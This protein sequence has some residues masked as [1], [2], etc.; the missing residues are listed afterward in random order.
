M[1]VYVIKNIEVSSETSIQYGFDNEDG[2]VLSI[3]EFPFSVKKKIKHSK[4]FEKK[5][6]PDLL[7]FRFI[8]TAGQSGPVQITLGIDHSQ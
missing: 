6:E 7:L 2:Q 5:T 8:S 3:N 4:F 1:V